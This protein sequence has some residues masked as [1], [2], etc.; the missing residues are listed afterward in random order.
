VV[1]TTL[2]GV[3]S[4]ESR[5]QTQGNRSQYRNSKSE[6]NEQQPGLMSSSL[7]S[8]AR[9]SELA[10][11]EQR[12]GTAAVRGI[13]S[14]RPVSSTSIK[15]Q[16]EKNEI[17][18]DYQRVHGSDQETA[19]VTEKKGKTS[20]RLR[21]ALPTQRILQRSSSFKSRVSASYRVADLSMELVLL[22]VF[23][24]G[25]LALDE[26]ESL[27]LLNSR[28]CRLVSLHLRLLDI[29]LSSVFQQ[30]TAYASQTELD[31]GRVDMVSALFIHYGGDPGKVVRALNGEYT[32]NHLDRDRIL[33]RL[34]GV[35]SEEDHEHIRRILYCGCPAAFHYEELN[36][37]RLMW[38]ERGNQPSYNANQDVARETINKEDKYSHVIPIHAELLYYSPFCRHT[39]QGMV[40]KKGSKDRV[41]WDGSTKYSAADIVMNELSSVELE[42]PITFG[43]V[44]KEFDEY[45][46]N[47]RIS[48][49]YLNILLATLDVAACF[50]FGRM[51]P[52]LAGAF[53]FLAGEDIYCLANAM[54]FGHLSS[55]N[56]WEPFRRAIQALSLVFANSQEL[57]EKHRDLLDTIEWVDVPRASYV[58]AHACALNPGVLNQQ[59]REIP[60]HSR[61]Y[62]DDALIAAISTQKMR[63]MLAATIEAIFV[64]MGEPELRLRRCPLAMDKWEKLVVSSE[65]TFLGLRYDTVTMTKGTTPEYRDDVRDILE[66]D[67]PQTRTHFT[68][69]DAQ[70]LVGKLARLAKGARWVFHILSHM[71]DQIAVALAANKRFLAASSKE[72]RQ[73]VSMITRN[74][75]G[76]G[77]IARNTARITS[78]ALKRAA[79]LVHRS[80]QRYLITAEMR[81]DLEFFRH[82]LRSDSG[83]PWSAPLAHIVKRTPFAN[84]FGDSSLGAAGGYSI[85]LSYWWHVPFPDDIVR[86]TLL[87]LK[88]DSSNTLISINALEFVT[89]IL[90]YCAAIT[91]LEQDNPT[92][93]PH[94]VVLGITDNTSSLNWTNH[95]CKRSPLGRALSRFFVGLLIGSNLG[96]NAEWISTDE[97]KIAD[98]I[99]RLKKADS[100]T[101]GISSFDYSSLPQK[102]PSLANCRFWEPA[103]ALLSAIWSILLSRKS[104]TLD[105][106]NRLKQSGLGKLST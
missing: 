8:S 96:I 46:F 103:P 72:F 19:I 16:Q 30:R 76:H 35:V 45:L 1:A 36:Q 74:Q 31:K 100:S 102:F 95:S 78:F 80:R 62:V 67:W 60:S 66:N 15:G 12:P 63:M 86:R 13:T 98:E 89:I 101:N 81:D 91:V 104:P 97:N 40:R 27:S 29:D 10:D 68:A 85:S 56:S 20:H 22:P 49:P 51:A 4:F 52:D 99:S 41:V 59:G 61:F 24:S 38:M 18:A 7:S 64:V 92:T 26:Y 2:A 9:I 71:Y 3:D 23:A 42:A 82:A 44:E 32:L 88:D 33:Q 73:L 94:P 50:R 106:V 43:L 37:D 48:Y 57:V 28:S 105:E 6:F 39:P 34:S 84:L 65:Q 21:S 75:N 90:N 93:D 11:G 83:I 58:Q 55:A 54:V 53:G 17:L 87:Y 5:F 69:K 70:K 14:R 47:L 25:F 77:Q 79:Q